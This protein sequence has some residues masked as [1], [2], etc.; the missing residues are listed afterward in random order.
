MSF[1]LPHNIFQNSTRGSA[2]TSKL[3]LKMQ[4]FLKE[5]FKYSRLFPKRTKVLHS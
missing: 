4:T 3:P 5:K 2:S 1:Y